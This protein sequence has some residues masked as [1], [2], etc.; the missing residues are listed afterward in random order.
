MAQGAHPEGEGSVPPA[1]APDA[2]AGRG[3][4]RGLR[5]LALGAGPGGWSQ[6]EFEHLR[7]RDYWCAWAVESLPEERPRQG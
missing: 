7:N 6:T 4:E 3:T 5:V 2:G 1:L